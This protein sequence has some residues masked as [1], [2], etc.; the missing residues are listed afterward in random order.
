MRGVSNPFL[1]L[2]T[3]RAAK[4]RV[5]RSGY[6]PDHG[7]KLLVIP[8]RSQ[9]GRPVHAWSVVR[10]RLTIS[11]GTGL[12]CCHG[13]VDRH[14]ASQPLSRVVRE[15]PSSTGSDSP[16]GYATGTAPMARAD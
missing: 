6:G 2:P 8:V 14:V 15:Y 4:P 7:L 12:S 3:N 16:I 11:L 10:Q 1:A 5:H 13:L 9:P